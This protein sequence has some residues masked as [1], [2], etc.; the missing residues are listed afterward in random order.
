MDSSVNVTIQLTSSEQRTEAE[1]HSQAPSTSTTDISDAG[2]TTD[3]QQDTD[4]TSNLDVELR[5]DEE[6]G[7]EADEESDTESEI[8]PDW[9]PVGFPFLRQ[10]G[11]TLASTPAPSAISFAEH[12]RHWRDR[13]NQMLSTLE[14]ANDAST[15]LTDPPTHKV[16]VEILD[17]AEL[18]QHGCGLHCPCDLDDARNVADKIFV[19]SSESG[20][21]KGDVLRQLRDHVYG[22]DDEGSYPW[23][24]DTF[25]GGLD[26]KTFNWLS[27]GQAPAGAYRGGRR[28]E[29]L[30]CVFFEV[31]GKRK[32]VG[33]AADEESASHGKTDAVE[34]A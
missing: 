21:T 15:Q 27:Y 7:E 1:V 24:R 29:E 11:D 32:E 4:A 17:H 19:L 25:V 9:K 18:D 6:A 23:A 31:D 28:D 12:Q 30:P 22:N 33:K 20:L 26:F 3:D 16:E 5:S 8:V 34:E 2:Q 10:C 13:F 14:F